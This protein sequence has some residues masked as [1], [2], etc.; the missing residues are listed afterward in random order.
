VINLSFNQSFDKGLTLFASGFY[1]QSAKRNYGLFV[2]LT[3]SLNDDA[4]LTVAADADRQSTG[5]RAD[6]QRSL[7]PD[8]GSWG[9]SFSLRQ[10]N[11]T[12]VAADLQYRMRPGLLE[13]SIFQQN[14]STDMFALF[15]GSLVAMGGDVFASQRIDNAFAVV[16]AGAP[17]VSVLLENRPIGTTSSNNKLLVTGLNAY[18][19]NK[20]SIDPTNLPLTADIPTTTI[21]VVPAQS[22]GAL[23][24]FKI[25]EALPSAI[26]IF[27]MPDNSLVEAGV[28]GHRAGADDESF[29]VGYDGRAFI[30]GLAADNEVILET[31]A[32]PCTATFQFRSQK[33]RIPV[34]GPV[35]CRL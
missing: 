19:E 9:G 11:Q 29:F 1:S 33:N 4:S 6:L 22:S 31:K 8:I 26:V 27:H 35:S 3:A 17:D 21:I 10:S 20:I 13:G 34:I 5:V 25:V 23:A 14:H 24:R 28:Q 15:D 32:G 18:Q 16:D 7:G 2:G 12:T 30:K